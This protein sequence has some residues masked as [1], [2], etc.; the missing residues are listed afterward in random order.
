LF[1]CRPQHA[2]YLRL[3]QPD[4][5]ARVSQGGVGRPCAGGRGAGCARR[6]GGSWNRRCWLSPCQHLTTGVGRRGRPML[7]YRP[8]RWWRRRRLRLRRRELPR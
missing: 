2:R 7:A 3:V 4:Q 6:R 1:C 5:L 8:R